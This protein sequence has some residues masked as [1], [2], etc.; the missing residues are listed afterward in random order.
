M[1]ER[2]SKVQLLVG[3]EALDIALCGSSNWDMK[4]I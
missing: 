2:K 3:A 4:F 1:D